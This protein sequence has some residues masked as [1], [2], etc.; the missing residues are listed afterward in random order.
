MNCHCPHCKKEL[1]LNHAAEGAVA[2][3]CYCQND[4]PITLVAPEKPTADE[5][6]LEAI[7]G[8]GLVALIA[9][10]GKAA[11]SGDV[12]KE[13]IFYWVLCGVAVLI[14][15]AIYFAP[16]L[17]ARNRNHRNIGALFVLNLLL[18]WTVLGW[19]GALV[20]ALVEQ[21]RG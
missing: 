12:S 11:I 18:G 10:V 7:L 15:V 3:C 6:N 5:I 1:V 8:G 20:W 14:G 13:V 9:V 4:F 21:E 17:V 19:V 2:K 16:T